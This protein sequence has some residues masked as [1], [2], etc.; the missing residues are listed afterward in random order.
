ML[1]LCSVPSLTH[2]RTYGG[3]SSVREPTTRPRFPVCLGCVKSGSEGC[4]RSRCTAPSLSLL[5]VHTRTPTPIPP[6]PP[7]THA[8]VTSSSTSGSPTA[9]TDPLQ[10]SSARGPRVF[11]RLPACPGRAWSGSEGCCRSG[12]TAPS[13]HT[14]PYLISITTPPITHHHPPP[15]PPTH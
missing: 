15:H 1:Y 5:H 6:L 10:R 8:H 3:G 13:M 14:P 4:C 9:F 7:H 12:C 11:A 2:S